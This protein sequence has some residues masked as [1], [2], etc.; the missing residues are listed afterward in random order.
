MKI[1][2]ATALLAIAAS[3]STGFAVAEAARQPTRSEDAALLPVVRASIPAG[4]RSTSWVRTRVST[5]APRWAAFKINP[6][7]GYEG[8]VQTA[9]GYAQRT[10]LKWRV[11]ELGTSGVGCLGVPRS[12]RTELRR[13]VQ[14]QADP[15]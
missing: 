2:L 10:G 13:A 9:Y 12:V 1:A 14:W 8:V 3:G 11:V 5:I 4:W 6:R 15:C 7:S